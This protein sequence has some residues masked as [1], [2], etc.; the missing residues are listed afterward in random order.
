MQSYVQYVVQ[1]KKTVTQHPVGGTPNNCLYRE[2]P[3]ERGTFSGFR[4]TAV[5]RKI[6]LQKGKSLRDNVESYYG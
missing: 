5:S 2:A 3:A 1:K 6:V 4:Y